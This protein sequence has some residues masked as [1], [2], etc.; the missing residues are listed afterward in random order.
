LPSHTSSSFTAGILYTVASCW[1][2]CGECFVSRTSWSNSRSYG[3]ES[4][5]IYSSRR[6]LS[7]CPCVTRSSHWLVCNFVFSSQWSCN[8]CRNFGTWRIHEDQFR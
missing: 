4:V 8:H 3:W 7:C 1:G 2:Y 6:A 5:F